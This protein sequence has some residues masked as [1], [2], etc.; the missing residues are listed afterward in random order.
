[1][2][3]IGA[4]PATGFGPWGHRIRPRTQRPVARRRTRG[5]AAGRKPRELNISGFL[6]AIVA[7]SALAF[8][9]L[10]QSSH[11]AATGY[12][13]DGLQARVLELRMEQQQ[14]IFDIGR[15]R[16]PSVIEE[17]ARKDLKLTPIGPDRTSFAS[18]R[19]S[20]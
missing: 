13:I 1:M 3:V 9:Y 5:S 6:I 14:L 18:D 11:V 16:S 4:R 10:S 7:A 19:P 2:A 20:N 8:F 17:S 15:A 12:V